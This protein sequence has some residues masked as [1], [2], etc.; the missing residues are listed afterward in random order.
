[1]NLTFGYKLLLACLPFLIISCGE[2]KNED[3]TE[4]V[5]K[6]GS[7]ETAVQVTHLDSGRDLLTTTHKV[8][9]KFN[10]YKTVQYHDTIPGLGVETTVAENEEGDTKNVT[11]PKDYE[12]YITVK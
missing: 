1:M 4:T 5:N 6:N 11:V 12:I 3:V 8:W 2:D 9:V 10:E 7:I